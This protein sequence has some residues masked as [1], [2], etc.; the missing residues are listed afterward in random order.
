MRQLVF[1]I[2]D[3]DADP[4]ILNG[5]FAARP[6]YLVRKVDYSGIESALTAPG[7]GPAAVI[8]IKKVCCTINLLLTKLS[9]L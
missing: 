3:S 9:L 4:K 7:A 1:Y 5:Y 6:F 8:L 2:P